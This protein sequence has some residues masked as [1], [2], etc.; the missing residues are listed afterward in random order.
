MPELPVKEVRLP[1]LHL[2]EIDRDQIVSSLSGLRLPIGGHPDDRAAAV[3]SQER[4][5]RF[6]LGSHRLARPSTWARPS[7]VRRPSSGPAHARDR[8]SAPAGWSW[9]RRGRRGVRSPRR[10]SGEP[11]VRERDGQDGPR[12]SCPDR[13][14]PRR[15]RLEIDADADPDIEP[16][17]ETVAEDVVTATAMSRPTGRGRRQGPVTEVPQAATPV[18]RARSGVDPAVQRHAELGR[19]PAAASERDEDADQPTAQALRRPLEVDHDMATALRSRRHAIRRDRAGPEVRRVMEGEAD[20][21]RLGPVVALARP[22]PAED[23]GALG[24][25][26]PRVAKLVQL[27]VLRIEARPELRPARSEVGQGRD[28]SIGRDRAVRL[29]VDA[30]PRLAGRRRRLRRDGGR[31]ESWPQPAAGCFPSSMPISLSQRRMFR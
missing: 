29:V 3:R 20:E 31:T 16:D 8:S 10:R 2:P 26:G 5:A 28:E 30:S 11:A 25:V 19:E 23:V 18:D 24:H 9:R 15:D 27:V 13:R 22:H 7:P 17:V 21:A 14:S 6:D 1:E 12:R 4:R